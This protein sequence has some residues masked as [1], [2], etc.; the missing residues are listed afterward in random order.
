[1]TTF[2]KKS[3]QEIF[4]D[5]KLNG[6]DGVILILDQIIIK[7][8][9]R[10]AK[11][12]SIEH[13]NQKSSNMAM[14]EL[15]MLEQL[16]NDRIKAQQTVNTNPLIRESRCS[17]NIM[18]EIEKYNAEIKNRDEIAIATKKALKI[19]ANVKYKDG[20]PV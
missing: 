16:L 2:F 13:V 11:I 14:K 9:Q 4:N 8:S 6:I 15:K 12:F 3:T 10:I 18:A 17:P 19:L 1:M 5:G 20:K 7:Q